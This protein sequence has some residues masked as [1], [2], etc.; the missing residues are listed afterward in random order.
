MRIAFLQSAPV[1]LAPEVNRQA[2]GEQLEHAFAE[3]EGADLVVL[4]ELFT[5]GYFFRSTEDVR[6]VSEKIPEGPTTAWLVA[7]AHRLNTTLV[8]GLPEHSGE[9]LYNSAVVCSPD[10]FVGVYRKTH[11]YYEEKLH[12]AS[13]TEGFPVLDLRTRDGM[14][15]RLGVMICFDWF[16]PESARTLALKGADII[17]HPSNLVRPNCPRAMPI[18][19][20]ENRVYTITANRTGR[21]SS[22]KEE[23][24]FIGQS[25]ICSPGGEVLARADREGT[26][27]AAVEI[28]LQAAR[29]KQ[30]TAHNELWDDR[31]P[32]GYELKKVFTPRR[33][34]DPVGA[35]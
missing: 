1:Y 5:S 4:P 7:Q 19:A 30:L 26:A 3:G 32:E 14:A 20:L 6:S 35:E 28:D 12:F 25:E 21:E 24:L 23:L 9:D 13:G 8:A 33:A 29:N 11:L 17:A 22:G 10:G 16:F 34:V 31:R 2:V 15:Y 27:F 18:R